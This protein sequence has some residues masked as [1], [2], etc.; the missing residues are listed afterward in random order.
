MFSSFSSQKKYS[1]A[2]EIDIFILFSIKKYK[3]KI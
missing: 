1:E 2:I 3:L